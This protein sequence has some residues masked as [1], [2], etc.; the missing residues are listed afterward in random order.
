MGKELQFSVEIKDPLYVSPSLP[1]FASQIESSSVLLFGSTTT[2]LDLTA[3]SPVYGWA[4]AGASSTPVSNSPSV[5]WIKFSSDTTSTDPNAIISG[6]QK[7]G[8]Y[9]NRNTNELMGYAWSG[10]PCGQSNDVCGYGWISF[11]KADLDA[12]HLSSPAML[13]G[14]K[15]SGYA[16]FL[17]FDSSYSSFDGYVD[18]SGITYTSSTGVLSGSTKEVNIVPQIHFCDPNNPNDP[19]YCVYVS[20]TTYPAQTPKA[21]IQKPKITSVQKNSC[22]NG[23]CS[24]TVNWENPMDYSK[25]KIMMFN[26]D[27]AKD[28]N[29]PNSFNRCK[30]ESDVTRCWG[31]KGKFSFD[32]TDQNNKQRTQT[33]DRDYKIDGLTPGT[34]YYILIRAILRQ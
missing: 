23:Y 29:A 34:T 16:K 31:E 17:S 25:V 5:G 14:D 1:V 33:G 3:I 30:T 6:T 8:V 18:L 32:S 26:V 22:S 24:I 28:P 19:I 11:N 10:V 27:E 13:S 7:Y 15:L 2:E 21:K 20:S 4:W 9:L 12:A